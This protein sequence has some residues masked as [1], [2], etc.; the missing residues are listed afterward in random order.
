MCDSVN[1]SRFPKEDHLPD[2]VGRDK[3]GNKGERVD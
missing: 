3:H 1:L 2:W